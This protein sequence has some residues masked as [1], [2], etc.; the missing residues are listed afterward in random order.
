[1][2]VQGRPSLRPTTTEQQQWIMVAS[3]WSACCTRLYVQ[4][5]EKK[6]NQ[7]SRQLLQSSS[8]IYGGLNQASCFLPASGANK[9]KNRD[10]ESRREP[11]ENYWG[12]SWSFAQPINSNS[13]KCQDALPCV[14][15]ARS[16]ERMLCTPPGFPLSPGWLNTGVAPD[17]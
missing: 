11:T 4:Y 3:C 6:R 15:L 14:F 1:M 17:I 12:F 16:S 13:A 5:Q 8:N 10:G 9:Q 2:Y 7:C